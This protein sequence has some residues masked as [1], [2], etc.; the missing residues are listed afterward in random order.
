MKKVVFLLVD[1]LM[2]DILEDCLRHRTVP[3]LQFLKERGRYWSDC[4]TVF[5]TMTA[6]VDSSLVT[7]VYPNL[8]RIPGLIWYHPQEKKIINYV[9]GWKCVWKLGIDQC[10]KNV[11]YNLNEK[12]LSNHVTTLF[13]E[14]AFRGKTSASINTIIHRGPKKYRAK[15]PFLIRLSSKFRIQHEELSGPDVL[16]LGAFVPTAL[17]EK[18]PQRLR[19]FSKFYG[20][21]DDYAVH[22]AKL[23]IESGNQPDFMLVY[24]P[25][26]DHAV[27][28]MSPAHAEGALIRADQ[29]IQEILNTFGSWDEALKKCVFIISSDHGQT[30]IGNGHDYIID[31]DQLLAP[32][33]VLQLGE[34]LQDHDLVVCNNER[35][36]YLYP[37]KPGQQE[38]IIRQ[39]LKES[40]IDLI[41]WKQG[42]G[43]RVKEGGSGREIYFEPDGPYRDI[44]GN[45]WAINGEWEVLDLHLNGEKVDYRDYPDALS[46]LYGALY[47]QEVPMIVITAR[48][49]YEI[50]T[51]LFPKHLKGG[52]HGSLHKYDSQIP[53]IVSGTDRSFTKPPRLIDLKQFIIDL[54]E[55]ESVAP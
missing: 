14:L 6:S 18:I 16:T 43:V 11:L 46:R 23:L 33:H 47:S 35:M 1:S 13:E 34:E 39:L 54:F 48:P 53:L 9:N 51:R 49:R 7:G 28:K 30:R 2:P 15:L 4:V 52:C 38:K 45:T 26:N 5:P 55:A 21:N 8:H 12:H 37:L 3:A 10:A 24:L 42:Q 44:Y 50:M 31:L 17:N 19:R 25:D 36:A 22:A 41:A 29:R 32:F 40:R 27:H 20:I